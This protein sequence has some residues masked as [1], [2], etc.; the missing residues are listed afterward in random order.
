MNQFE[1]TYRIITVNNPHRLEEQVNE[2]L[3]KGYV[4]GTILFMN[5]LIFCIV[6]YIAIKRKK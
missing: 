1:R 5:F 2:F 3:S 6:A 4:L